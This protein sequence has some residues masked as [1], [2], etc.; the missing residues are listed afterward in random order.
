L[1]DRKLMAADLTATLDVS[2][3]VF[4]I[5]GTPN[6]AI[7]GHLA[8][9]TQLKTAFVTVPFLP[10]RTSASS[11]VGNNSSVGKPRKDDHGTAA[12]IILSH[13]PAAGGE[14]KFFCSPPATISHGSAKSLNP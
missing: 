12:V 3:H 9:D 14:P 7:Q 5:E 4:R 2:T 10:L 13:F 6:N 11:A 1:E 8:G